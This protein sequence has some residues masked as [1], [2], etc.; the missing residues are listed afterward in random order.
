MRHARRESSRRCA[1]AALAAGLIAL[2]VA[3]A[4]APAAAQLAKLPPAD[5][6]AADR[7]WA[8]FKTGLLAALEKRDK[9]A[10]IAA[11]DRNVRNGARVKPGIDEFRRQWDIDAQDSALWQVLTKI[12]FLGG[13]NVKAAN[14]AK[15][16]CAP[17]VAT[18]W[19]E[20][21]DPFEHGAIIARE[22][23][24]KARPSAASA[25]IATLSY[26]IV[27]IGEWDI[28]DETKGSTQTWVH[29]DTRAG[30]GYVPAEQIRSPVEH[31]ACFAGG[32][33]R[34]RIT[35]LSAGDDKTK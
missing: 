2:G 17:Y 19:P 14:G 15:E 8:K 7:S 27:E 3:L 35:A 11:L 34:W 23:L 24:V 4:A 6:A 13:R 30:E 25:T 10:L 16:F 20:Q 31:R 18:D 28:E 33:G 29:V 21:F 9:R 32:G 5:D 22:A 12:L 26:D 1:R